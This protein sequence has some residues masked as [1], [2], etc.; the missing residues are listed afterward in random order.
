[1]FPGV[2]C[3]TGALFIVPDN[4]SARHEYE[5][6]G[7]TRARKNECSVYVAFKIMKV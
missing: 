2:C 7:N 1:M 5:K 6:T 3:F 4:S